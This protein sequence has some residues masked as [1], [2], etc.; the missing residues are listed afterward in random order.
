METTIAVVSDQSFQ[1]DVLDSTVPVL[2]DFWAP[3]CAPCRLITPLLDELAE[4]YDGKY[5]FMSMNTDENAHVPTEYAI[6]S[7]PTLGIFRNGRMV[8]IVIGARSKE[9]IKSKLDEN[10]QGDS[11]NEEQDSMPFSNEF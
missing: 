6:R 7:I 9:F 11:Y 5:R 2:V 1:K 8:D 3:W 4:E 10:L